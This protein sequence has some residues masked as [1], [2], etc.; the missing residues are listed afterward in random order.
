MR[1]WTSG[2]ETTVS[3]RQIGWTGAMLLA[4]VLALWAAGYF[5]GAW[6]WL[7]Y[8]WM[9][10]SS[11]GAGPISV[12]GEDRAGTSLGLSDFLF[13]QGQEIVIGYD[14]DITAGSLYFHVF[15]PYDGVLG[16]GESHYVTASGSGTWTWRVPKSGIYTVLIQPSV[17]RGAGRGFDLRYSAWWGARRAR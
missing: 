11:F 15:Q 4:A 6:P 7:G 9:S 17:V 10:R 2:G 3:G 8:T 5:A 13:L 16:D 12:I 14:A 1:A